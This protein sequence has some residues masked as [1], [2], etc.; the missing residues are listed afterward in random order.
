MSLHLVYLVHLV[1][2]VLFKDWPEGIRISLLLPLRRRS[3]CT[4]ALCFLKCTTLLNSWFCELLKHPLN[5]VS[6]FD[7]LSFPL[8]T[9]RPTTR[10]CLSSCRFVSSML[11][12]SFGNTL[13]TSASEDASREDGASLFFSVFFRGLDLGFCCVSSVQSGRGLYYLF[14]P[15]W[16]CGRCGCG[17]CRRLLWCFFIG[18]VY[19]GLRNEAY[20][21]RSQVYVFLHPSWRPSSPKSVNCAHVSLEFEIRGVDFRVRWGQVC[22]KWPGALHM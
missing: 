21:S 3:A 8:A 10:C 11:V 18:I 17:L 5:R 19:L 12:V 14:R 16:L 1:M 6:F 20:I 4:S 2:F 9:S 13:T 15:V 7:V 22:D